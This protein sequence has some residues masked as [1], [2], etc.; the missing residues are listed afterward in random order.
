MA[1]ALVATLLL[2]SACATVQGVGRDVQS[3][4]RGLQDVSQDVKRRMSH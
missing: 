2:L 3:L 4:G 1:A